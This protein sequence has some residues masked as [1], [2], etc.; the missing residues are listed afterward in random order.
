M[1]CLVCTLYNTACRVYIHYLAGVGSK[2]RAWTAPHVT[3]CAQA[4]LLHLF[5]A[6]VIL[7]HIFSILAHMS[8]HVHKRCFYICSHS[9]EPL[10]WYELC[11]Y[12]SYLYISTVFG[13][14]HGIWHVLM[15]LLHLCSMHR[16]F[17]ILSHRCIFSGTFTK[18]WRPAALRKPCTAHWQ[19]CAEFLWTF[20]DVVLKES[21]PAMPCNAPCKSCMVHCQMLH[22][23]LQCHWLCCH[24][25]L[26]RVIHCCFFVAAF[27]LS[28]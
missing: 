26:C 21:N 24:L 6:S 12:S 20:G 2:S 7:L 16:Y 8:L 25:F 3:A 15:I 17:A 11:T 19:K 18:Y 4:L 28:F 23:C 5:T 1:Y 10:L 9:P 27:L 14:M 13:C 22:R